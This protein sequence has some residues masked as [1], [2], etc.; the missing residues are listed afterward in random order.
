M[1]LSQLLKNQSW[2]MAID[3]N[4]ISNNWYLNP[5]NQ[6]KYGK[7]GKKLFIYGFLFDIFTLFL[8]FIVIYICYIIANE[9]NNDINI[10]NTGWHI[11]QAIIVIEFL[12]K[13]N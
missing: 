11:A 6:R 9:N 13:V 12:L 4:I 3:P 10:L 5:E 2:Q 8:C 1:Q 7:R